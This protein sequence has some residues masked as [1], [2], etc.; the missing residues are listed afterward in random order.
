MDQFYEG[1][2]TPLRDVMEEEARASN[3]ADAAA[4]AGGDAEAPGDAESQRDAESQ[5]SNNED[6]EDSTVAEAED[7]E[8]GG[9]DGGD[10]GDEESPN[11]DE[12]DIE[13]TASGGNGTPKDKKTPS[14]QDVLAMMG[15]FAGLTKELK[16]L[17]KKASAKEKSKVDKPN[18][19]EVLEQNGHVQY[20]FGGTPNY[21]W[22]K[23]VPL[24]QRAAGQYRSLDKTKGKKVAEGIDNLPVL[25]NTN[26]KLNDL[27][28]WATDVAID[29]GLYQHAF[30][31]HPHKREMVN[32]INNPHMLSTNLPHVIQAS[33]KIAAKYD[34]WDTENDRIL[35]VPGVIFGS[36][37]GTPRTIAFSVT[38]Y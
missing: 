7:E 35:R 26:H 12:E 20:R 21:H 27:Q 32:V 25:W 37:L 31:R 4:E 2:E 15:L 11:S 13:S 5:G 36:N 22:T 29:N 19:A 23:F 16:Q 3:M 8:N 33:A 14:Q 1:A 10:A 17:N 9:E 24:G 34:S 18:M 28:D 30:V 38:L 6:A